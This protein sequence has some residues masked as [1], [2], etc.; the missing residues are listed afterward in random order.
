MLLVVV[1]VA[2][3]NN[4]QLSVLVN[5]Y[6]YVMFILV[7]PFGMPKT[8]VMIFALITGITVG[9]FTNNAGLHASACITLAL[10]RP[11]VLK[12]LAPREGYEAETAPTISDMG[13]KWFLIYSLILVFIHH[14]VLF[15][16]EVFRFSE[17]LTTL[18]RVLLSSFFSILLIIICQYL[19]SKSK[20]QR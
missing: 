19:F 1:Q 18:A 20:A 12:L 6:L 3:L 5:P 17:F 10:A 7:L 13:F 14:F 2:I 4:I 16:L 8:I 9:V 11:A 15:F